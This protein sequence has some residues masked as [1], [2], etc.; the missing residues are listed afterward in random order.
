MSFDLVRAPRTKGLHLLRE[1]K[2]ADSLT[3]CGYQDWTPVQYRFPGERR[4][5]ECSRLRNPTTPGE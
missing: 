2:E 5:A 4:C 3:L 1:P